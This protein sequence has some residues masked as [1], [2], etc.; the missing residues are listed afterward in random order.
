MSKAIELL[1]KKKE[2]KTEEVGDI[3]TAPSH[4]NW[5]PLFECKELTQHLPFNEGNVIKYLYRCGFKG[6]P[7]QTLQDKKKA[8]QYIRMMKD[9]TGIFMHGIYDALESFFV[10]IAN[11]HNAI[12]GGQYV[13]ASQDYSLIL[14]CSSYFEDVSVRQAFTEVMNTLTQYNL[15]DRTTLADR[16]ARILEVS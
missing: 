6:T 12:K 5:H 10:I 16:V 8:L 1:Q 7:E 2:N 4:Y 3:I 11:R 14:I 15:H 9:T 13:Q